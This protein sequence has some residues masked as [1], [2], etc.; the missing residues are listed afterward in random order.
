MLRTDIVR[1][2]LILRLRRSVKKEKTSSVEEAI[3]DHKEKPL[4]IT[5][6]LFKGERLYDNR[7]RKILL[8]LVREQT[9]QVVTMYHGYRVAQ[10]V[11]IRQY[12]QGIGSKIFIHAP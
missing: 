11:K 1:C 5:N 12:C 4:C 10:D 7:N 9:A 2:Y 8:D 6:G 3:R